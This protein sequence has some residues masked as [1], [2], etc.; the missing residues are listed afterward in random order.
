MVSIE[1]RDLYQLLISEFRYSV[2]RD[3]HLAPGTCV[4]LVMQ[5]LPKLSKEWQAHTAEQLTNEIIQERLFIGGREKGRLDQ[6]AEWERLLVFL[7][8]YLTKLPYTVERYM[9]YIYNKPS[10]EANID[11]Y[12]TEIAEKIASNQAK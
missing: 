7:T 12:S 5:Y 11:Y 9:Q 3:N 2:K 4:D 1:D 10:W 6:D 8:N